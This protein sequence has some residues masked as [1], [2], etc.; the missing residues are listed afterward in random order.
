MP[1]AVVQSDYLYDPVDENKLKSTKDLENHPNIALINGP[2]CGVTSSDRVNGNRTKL[3]ELPWMALLR[4]QTKDGENMFSCGGTLI[5]P[6]YIL[7][8]AHCVTDSSNAKL[9]SVRLG[10]YDLNA[11]EDC[12]EFAGKRMCAPLPQDIAVERV[13]LHRD[14]EKTTTGD[15]IALVRLAEDAHTNDGKAVGYR[16]N[17]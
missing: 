5:S 12:E 1:P 9:V 13:L 15:D 4:Y 14:Y 17:N 6:R 2:D 7:T 3:Y 8:A 16:L 10:E 11:T